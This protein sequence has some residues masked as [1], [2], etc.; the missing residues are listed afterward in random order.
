MIPRSPSATAAYSVINVSAYLCVL[1][2][3]QAANT[4]LCVGDTVGILHN[5]AAF[6][7]RYKVRLAFVSLLFRNGFISLCVLSLTLS[8]GSEDLSAVLCYLVLSFSEL[9]CSP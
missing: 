6:S 8:L 5:W 3:L 1:R 9:C 4:Y 7:T 2:I